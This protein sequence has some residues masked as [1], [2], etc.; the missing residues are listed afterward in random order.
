MRETT[1]I[2]SLRPCYS[3]QHVI[4]LAIEHACIAT[5]RRGAKERQNVAPSGRR[6]TSSCDSSAVLE[7]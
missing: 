1:L 7:T 4:H 6:E 5:K 2:M 3:K